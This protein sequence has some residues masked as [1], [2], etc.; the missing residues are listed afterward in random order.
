MTLKKQ[1]ALGDEARLRGVTKTRRI[2][3]REMETPRKQIVPTMLLLRKVSMRA[4]RIPRLETMKALL[5]L[6]RRLIQPMEL[7]SRRGV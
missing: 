4:R 7:T 1:K 2:M 3:A 5:L 6:L